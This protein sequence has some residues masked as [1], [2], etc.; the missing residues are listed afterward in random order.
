MKNY[1]S[2]LDATN[3]AAR[4]P[5]V[6]LLDCSYSMHDEPI[7]ELNS[8]VNRFFAEVR[9]DD[10]AA[11]S[12]DIAVVT[13]NTTANVAHGFASALDYPDVLDPFEAD[14][15]TA[16][17]PALELAERLLAEREAEYCKAGIPHYKPWCICL[18]DGV[19]CPNKGWRRP[20]QR[21]RDKAA[22]GD[23]TYLVVGVGDSINEK[24]LAE[25]S[26]EE[27]GVKRLQDLRFSEFFVWL[28]QSMHD[29]SVAG[30]ANQDDVRLRGISSWARFAKP[31]KG[32]AR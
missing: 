30:T 1:D 32:G 20:A 19:P 10:A 15:L 4:V 3:P 14:G 5:V 21:F 17:G 22:S 8:G 23:L 7:A 29:I 25:L 13:F 9:N 26:A 2:S 11:M 31:G 6:M 27:P 12:A 16:T 18:T 24:I 28:S